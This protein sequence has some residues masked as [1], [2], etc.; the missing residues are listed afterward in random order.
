MEG[1]LSPQGS[2]PRPVLSCGDV[3]IG[4]LQFRPA[5][6]VLLPQA[7]LTFHPEAWLRDRGRVGF[8]V[9]AFTLLDAP[10]PCSVT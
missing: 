4:Y 2:V 3:L 7:L 1:T 5:I 8:C 6:L 9:Q 10:Q